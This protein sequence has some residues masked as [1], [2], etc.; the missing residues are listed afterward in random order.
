MPPGANL[1]EVILSDPEYY[2]NIS[3]IIASTTRE[4]LHAYF[5]WHLIRNW[6]GGLHKDLNKPLRVF[7]NQ[8]AGLAEN[9]IPERWK[10]CSDEIDSRLGWILSGFYVE[11]AFSPE[12]KKYGERIIGNIKTEFSERLKDLDWMS[13]AVKTRA[14]KKG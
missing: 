13:D 9:T 8:M 14:A 7:N 1:S 6:A 2:G 3:S 12:A 10:S 5:Q 4:T 11:R